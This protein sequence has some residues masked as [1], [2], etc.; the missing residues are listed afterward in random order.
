[1][2]LLFKDPNSKTSE[3]S[4]GISKFWQSFSFH[5]LLTMKRAVLSFVLWSSI[6]KTLCISEEHVFLPLRSLLLLKR[7]FYSLIL[8][9]FLDLTYLLLMLK[10]SWKTFNCFCSFF[11]HRNLRL[12]INCFR[13]SLHFRYLPFLC[14]RSDAF[15]WSKLQTSSSAEEMSWSIL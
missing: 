11:R 5:L 13:I 7:L 8:N 4:F 2:S 1:M 10:G 6:F 12:S 3:S 9:D 15:C 14:Q